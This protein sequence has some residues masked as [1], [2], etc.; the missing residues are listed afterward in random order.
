MGDKG[1][2]AIE[3]LDTEGFEKAVRAREMLMIVEFYTNSCPNCKAMEPIYRKVASDL[4]G[5]AYCARVNAQ[6][7]MELVMRYGIQSVPTFKFLCR[8]RPVGEIV[9]AVNETLLRN[10]IVDMAQNRAKC[11]NSATVLSYD[12]TGYA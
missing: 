2:G 7:H 4:A 1:K 10:T 6:G 5:K 3:E 12:L 9:G 11:V 8:G